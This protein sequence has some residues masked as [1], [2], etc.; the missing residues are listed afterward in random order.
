MRSRAAIV[1]VV[2]LLAGAW[3]LTGLVDSMTFYPSA[4]PVGRWE[5]ASDLGA[6]DVELE[7]ADG[8]R[9]H[10]WFIPAAEQPAPVATVFL[11]GNAGNLSHREEHIGAITRSGSD[12]LILDYRGYG[13]SAGKPSEQG[14]YLDA[15]AGYDWLVARSS[16]RILCHGESLGTAVATELATR[17]PC[18]GLILEAPF[19]SRS[20]MAAQVVP[21][22]GPWVARGFDTASKIPSVDAPVWIL[23][24][25]RDGVVPQRLGRRVFEAARE[26]KQFWSI[27]GAGHNDILVR[28]GSEYVRRL[29]NFYQ[30]LGGEEPARR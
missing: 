30:G 21:V 2:C 17:R 19:T 8:V 26:P 13:K 24:G 16:A 6:E 11:H 29:Q 9:L 23:H 14:L 3:M 12:L 7:A 25:S 22:V 20:E 10:A 27:D 5:L 15:V 1:I 4:Y 28:A 18:A